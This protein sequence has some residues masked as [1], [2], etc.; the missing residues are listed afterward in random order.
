MSIKKIALII[1]CCFLLCFTIHAQNVGV[2]G[3]TLSEKGEPLSFVGIYVKEI[4]LG[5]S[6][7]LDGKFEIK[8]EHGEYTVLFQYLSYK[9][10]E[11][12][13]KV[14]D[15]WIDLNVILQPTSY[16]LGEV[17]VKV[18]DEDPAYAIMRKAI[19]MA[20][21]YDYQVQEYSARVYVKGVGQLKHIPWLVQKMMDKDQKIDTG[22]IYLVENISDISF[23]QPNTFKEKA[24]SIRS[25]MPDNAPSPMNYINGSFYKADVNGSVSPLSPKAFTYYRFK[26]EG[27]FYEGDKQ[28]NKIKVIPRSEGDNLFEGN[29]YIVDNLWCIHSLNLKVM[30]EG[31]TIEVKQLYNEVQDKIWLPSSQS[32]F[33]YGNV[34]GFAFEGKYQASSSNYKIK[35]NEKLVPPVEIIDEKTEKE[36]IPEATRVKSKDEKELETLLQGDKKLTRKDMRK[37]MKIYEKEEEKKSEQPEV[38]SDYSTEI[39]SMAYKRDSTYWT[40][41]RA[42]PLTEIE[43]KSYKVKD[44]TVK[45]SNGNLAIQVG[46]NKLDTNKVKGKKHSFN[47]AWLLTG[48]TF[49]LDSTN[50]L[51]WISPLTDIN[52]NTVEGYVANAKLNY[53]KK[54]RNKDRF[55]IMPVMRYSQARD[56]F[57]GKGIVS[58]RYGKDDRSGSISAEGGKFISQFNAD[59]PISQILNSAVSL[60]FERNFMKIYEKEYYGLTLSQGVSDKMFITL[61][62]EF[63]NR[64]LLNNSPNSKSLF[65]WKDRTF[66]SNTPENNEISSTGFI[67]NRAFT[68]QLYLKLYPWKKYSIKNGI[69]SEMEGSSPEIK[70]GYR[71]GWNGLLDSDV[72]Y[73][74]LEAGVSHHLKW[75]IRGDLEGG[76]NAGWFPNNRKMYFMDYKHFMGN[77]TIIQQSV[78]GY[79]MLDYYAYSTDK[80]FAETF[81]HFQTRKLLLT[82]FA[83]ARMLALKENLF[84]NYLYAPSSGNYMEVGYGLDQIFRF[85]RFEVLGSFNNFKYQSLGFRI[86]IAANIGAK[87]N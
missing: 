78:T 30:D 32:Y 15:K 63:S 8:L 22:K 72:D 48:R 82:Q 58:Y 1:A 37:L 85:M 23:Q 10:E 62:G 45:V 9:T 42:I 81:L 28:I 70:L 52:F 6:S 47:I 57:S 25:N 38:I 77:S 3:I 68:T 40:E 76:I 33:I 17:V 50:T 36:K 34:Y 7:N 66:S 75:G 12:T 24:I 31:I 26:L 55:S 67:N 87:F 53:T 51:E 60:G 84:F 56:L 69:K 74:F 39:D 54:F 46:N 14:E 41:A 73:D 79:R 2:R 64:F 13:I 16:T 43:Q 83:E 71:K 35:L 86:G 20:K 80:Y 61:N 65:N 4:H 5:T 44:S 11:K 27:S 49:K 29:I 18:K 21:F 19:S 59:N